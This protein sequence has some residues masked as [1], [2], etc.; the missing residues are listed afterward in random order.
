MSSRCLSTTWGVACNE[1]LQLEWR[2]H[3]SPSRAREQRGQTRPDLARLRPPRWSAC[4]LTAHSREQIRNGV[5]FWNTQCTSRERGLSL[6]RV[7]PGRHEAES[8]DDRLF[9]QRCTRTKLYKS[10]MAQGDL[11]NV[12]AAVRRRILYCHRRKDDRERRK[13]IWVLGHWAL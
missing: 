9:D 4:S 8:L 10:S 2:N 1:A 3:L 13:T 7:P 12:V 6:I 5:K 11:I